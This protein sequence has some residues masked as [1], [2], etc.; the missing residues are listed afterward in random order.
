MPWQNHDILTA[1][2][3]NAEKSNALVEWGG[4]ALAAPIA[5]TGYGNCKFPGVI[6]K[7]GADFFLFF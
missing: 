4:T 3:I 2:Q 6:S 5:L 7:N 1:Q